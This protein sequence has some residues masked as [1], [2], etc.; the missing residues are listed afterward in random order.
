[1]GHFCV[2]SHRN[3]SSYSRCWSFLPASSYTLGC[4]SFIHHS[5]P[6]LSPPP[7]IAVPSTFG[8]QFSC[9]GLPQNC[10][11]PGFLFFVV[12]HFKGIDTLKFLLN[13][14]HRVYFDDSRKYP[15][16][17]HLPTKGPKC[18]YLKKKKLEKTAIIP[19]RPGI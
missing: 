3:T 5:K 1:M 18:Y 12:F 19:Q 15:T 7:V 16:S 14:L 6:R 2:T 13:N 11:L 10:F 4:R 9:A 17:K 8:S